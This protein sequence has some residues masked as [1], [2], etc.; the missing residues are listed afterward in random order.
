METG[1]LLSEKLQTHFEDPKY[2]SYA[3][4]PN[5]LSLFLVHAI[6]GRRTRFSALGREANRARIPRGVR[7]RAAQLLTTATY[8]TAIVFAVSLQVAECTDS[9]M[10]VVLRVILPYWRGKKEHPL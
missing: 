5:V 8:P 7:S 10:Y 6:W 9:A 4:V 1:S 2:L 3:Y